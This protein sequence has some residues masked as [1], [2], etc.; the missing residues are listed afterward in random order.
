MNNCPRLSEALPNL[1]AEAAG[2]S[3]S[4]EIISETNLLNTLRPNNELSIVENSNLDQD[5]NVFDG[6]I[7][8]PSSYITSTYCKG[9]KKY[10]HPSLFY[11]HTRNRNFKQCSDCRQRNYTRRYPNAVPAQ[12]VAQASA[13]VHLPVEIK[14]N[15]P[16]HTVP[17]NCLRTCTKCR[18]SNPFSLFANSNDS[19][20][21]Y[22][23]NNCRAR[24]HARR[25]PTAFEPTQIQRE[26]EILDN[27]YDA[28][29]EEINELLANIGLS[30]IE[31]EEVFN[32]PVPE[33]API[34]DDPIFVISQLQSREF[35]NH[36]EIQRRLQVDEENNEI[37]N[38]DG[39]P[40]IDDDN[41]VENLVPNDP[42]I[43]DENPQI[44][45][46]EIVQSQSLDQIDSFLES[47]PP[48]Q[49]EDLIIIN[50]DLQTAERSEVIE[51]PPRRVPAWLAAPAARRLEPAGYLSRL[52]Q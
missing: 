26:N 46:N 32:G 3:I 15:P 19:S 51:A 34:G 52:G 20:L 24:L 43:E 36:D 33:E 29:D 6:P 27:I 12:S 16:I 2:P 13:N 48:P 49:A 5:N 17:N 1:E 42:L 21:L 18:K 41:Q 25:F 31:K 38:P 8:N 47:N 9:Y 35:R 45:N 10:C 39:T 30:V 28:G 11:D 14:S 37:N 40:Q 7:I 50:N 23:C 22:T 44:R 4:T